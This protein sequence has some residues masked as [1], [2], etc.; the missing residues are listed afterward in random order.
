[1]RAILLLTVAVPLFLHLPGCGDGSDKKSKT[2]PESET[3]QRLEALANQETKAWNDLTKALES[4]GKS[5][6]AVAKVNAA[7]DNVER[8]LK[9]PLGNIGQDASNLRELVDEYE[10]E[11]KQ[12]LA[13]VEKATESALKRCNDLRECEMAVLRAVGLISHRRSRVWVTGSLAQALARL[14]RL[15]GQ[16]HRDP[17]KKSVEFEVMLSNTSITNDDLKLLRDLPPFHRLFLRKT[18]ITGDALKH[19]AGLTTVY[20]LFLGDSKVGSDGLRHLHNLPALKQLGLKGTLVEDAGLAHLKQLSGSLKTIYL[21]RTKITNAGLK[22]LLVLE[23]LETLKIQETAIDD[24]GLR[25]LHSHKS[26]KYI[27][28]KGTKVTRKGAEA[29]RKARGGYVHFD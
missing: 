8:I 24:D 12:V 6:D 22:H 7:A 23:N 29:F 18:P 28:A 11:I 10:A 3:K 2:D 5:K 13:R 17:F 19:I 26:L 25:T 9:Q 4:I 21:E 1:M 15:G 20:D 16:L 14:R 27:Y